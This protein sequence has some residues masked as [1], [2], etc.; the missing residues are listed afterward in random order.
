MIIER[1]EELASTQEY[2][3]A[4]IENK[5]NLFVLAKRQ[6][7]GHGTKGRSFSSDAGGL[8]FSMLLFP[9]EFLAEN[10][11]LLMARTAV[12]VCKTLESFAL[13]PKIKWP[14]DI[15]LAKKK[16]CGILIENR[17]QG[18]RVDASLIGVGLNVNN[19]LPKELTEIA[20]SMRSALGKETDI[21]EVEERFRAFFFSPFSFEEYTERLGYI[22]QEATL[23]TGDEERRVTLLGVSE[24]G[25]L[26]VE[27]NGE[28][29]AFSAGEVTLKGWKK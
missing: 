11:F 15:H 24:K 23:Q 26:L 3:R 12:A 16:V 7:D 28:E 25:L 10:A 18:K 21:K 6:T 22:G 5:E 13:S 29:K 19:E 27:K 1:F 2:C 17:L 4:R 20:I 8:Y 9:K 14:N